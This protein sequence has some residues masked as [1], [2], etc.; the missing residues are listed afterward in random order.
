MNQTGNNYLPALKGLVIGLGILIVVSF[1]LLIYGFA[2]KIAG[3]ETDMG[4]DTVAGE[5]A[6]APDGFGESRVSVPAGCVVEE[7]RPD[8]EL[9]FL[10][11]GPAGVCERILVLESRTGRHV[12]DISLRP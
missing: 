12:G 5:T 3:L 10:R 7:M 2:T 11:L 6:A 1:G 8:G 4:D 9:L